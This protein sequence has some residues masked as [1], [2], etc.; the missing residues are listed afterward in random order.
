MNNL[1]VSL[2]LNRIAI[3]AYFFMA[4][5]CFA[6]WASRIPDIKQSLRLDD[7]ALGSILLA[8]TIGLLA[9]LPLSGWLV[10]RFG[11]R[12]VVMGATL[13]YACTL[14]VLGLAQAGWQLALTLFVFGIGG[15][16]LNIAVNTQAVSL[17]VQY[18]RS[19][20]AS[21]HGVWSL[22]GFSGALIGNAMIR[23]HLLPVQH[24]C[25]VSAI[26]FVCALIA[27][28]FTLR[29]DI[30]SGAGKPLFVWPDAALLKLGLI[31]MCCMICEG[32]MFD[33]SGVYFQKIV[34]APPHLVILGYTAFM[35]TM[36]GGRFAG[37]RLAMFF[38]PQRILQA[39]GIVIVTGL[40][41]A[42]IFPTIV[43]ATIGF[44]LVGI[45]VSSVVPLV[46]GAAGKSGTMTPGMALA[47]VSTIGYLGFLA[48]PPIIGFI[49]QAASL[50]WSFTLIAMLG[51]T[52]TIMASQAKLKLT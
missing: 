15:N 21:F 41:L 42:V 22:A 7:A 49:A 23:L 18:G 44:L 27:V 48:G 50:R 19:I 17:E 30:N 8:L 32:T 35:C 33:W 38:G 31:A 25:I 9:S 52:T 28:R 37:D 16:L 12:Y 24:F 34:K 43:V 2:K 47:A 14:P 10:S 5:I 45:G 29:K 26:V 4:G 1:P 51:F 13:F 11:S 20:M 39:S 36:A 6:S 46:Y 3:G 40:L